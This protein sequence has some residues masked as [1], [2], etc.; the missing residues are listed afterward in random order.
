MTRAKTKAK[1]LQAPDAKAD[2]EKRKARANLSSAINGA[3]VVDAYSKAMFGDEQAEFSSVVEELQ[4]SI[5]KVWQGD[6]QKCEAMLISQAVALQTIFTN[7]S[8]RSA[9][10]E[11]LNQMETYLRLALKAQAQAVRTIEALGELKNP[12]P[13]AFVKQ[14][15]ISNG[16][17][18]VNNGSSAQAGSF[19]NQQNKQSEA[20]HE[21]L[22][23]TRTSQAESRI[24]PAVET[25]GKVDRAEVGGR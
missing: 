16:P 22:E 3:A 19:K 9:K 7:L 10:Q 15:N 17:Q 23:D 18:Q 5:D 20:G 4:H 8:R 21:L 1:E 11:Y 24:N 2:L 6:M 25:M 12:R 14:A 13:V